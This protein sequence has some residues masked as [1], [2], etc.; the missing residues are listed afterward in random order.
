[1]QKKVIESSVTSDLLTDMS[2]DLGGLTHLLNQLRV[3]MKESQKTRHILSY[4]SISTDVVRSTTSCNNGTAGFTWH[5]LDNFLIDRMRSYFAQENHM[6]SSPAHF[7]YSFAWCVVLQT[8][9]MAPHLTDDCVH[10]HP[11]LEL[12]QYIRMCTQ[13]LGVLQLVFRLALLAYQNSTESS[14][15]KHAH[16]I[17]QSSTLSMT[18]LWSGLFFV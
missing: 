1:M 10:L 15:P 6:Y 11:Q 3:C 5:W 14:H 16:W 8:H 9:A 4:L 18:W 7:R 13:T 12:M 17:M 2:F